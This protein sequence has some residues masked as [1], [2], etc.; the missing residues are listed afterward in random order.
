MENKKNSVSHITHRKALIDDF[1]LIFEL[2]DQSHF[3]YP[4]KIERIRPYM[5]VVER[6]WRNGLS[7]SGTLFW[8]HIAEKPEQK[9]TATLT[10]WKTTEKSWM[11]QHLTS[12]KCP[13]VVG[14]MLRNVLE[15][16]SAEGCHSGQLWFRPE[17][18]Q[19]NK[20]FTPVFEQIRE[21]TRYVKTLCFFD[22]TPDLI[23]SPVSSI[24]IRSCEER[25]I[26]DL[27]AFAVK[28][29][30]R[31]FADAEDLS[32]RDVCL[33]ELDSQY[34]R[35]S[36]MRRRYC[37]LAA[38]SGRPDYP[39]GAAIAYRGSLGFNLSLL[40]NRCE[41][42]VDPTLDEKMSKAVIF[43]LI[44]AAKAAYPLNNNSASPCF[45]PFKY[46]PV[47][48]E[49]H[50][51]NF[52]HSYFAA[53]FKTYNHCIWLYDGFNEWLQAIG[54][55]YRK[56]MERAG[57]L[58]NIADVGRSKGYIM[59]DPRE[60]ERLIQK[61]DP[62]QVVESCILEHLRSGEIMLDLGCGPGVIL[63]EVKRR[64]PDAAV[65][66]ADISRSRTLEAHRHLKAY[67]KAMA[68]AADVSE[69][70]FQSDSFDLVFARFLFQF[71]KHPERILEEMIRVCSPG[72]TIVIQ[73]LDGQLLWHYPPD[74][75]LEKNIGD[76]IAF[77]SEHH[78][79]D[80]FV[81]RKL[82]HYMHNAGLDNINVRPEI[83][84][85]YPG[86]IPER[87]RRH[88]ELKLSI[89]LPKISGFLGGRKS[90]EKLKERFMNYLLREDTLTYSVVFTV[91]GKKLGKKKTG[92]L[93]ER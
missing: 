5:D 89:I 60:A 57:R 19:V 81:G 77:L 20:L 91:S 39:I 83:Y 25:D 67:S 74:A 28:I 23:P 15:K 6:N 76:A 58:K 9:K 34:R 50:L 52:F 13:D 35:F 40:E 41:L 86:K 69:L 93:D 1:P 80:P 18:K 8:T 61:V 65:V 36:L 17:N 46:I 88:W 72:K 82:Y 30:G 73:D 32:N 53:P 21:N 22:V 33:S 55:R 31:V 29:R 70:P 3:F 38:D 12:N 68:V 24:A 44:Q 62:P 78:G 10:A 43:S 14:K 79:F 63:Q 87:N 45:Y 56:V 42:I 2:Y 92:A 85:L 7:T 4:K 37:W 59:D 11:A 49:T 48:V 71:M 26:P 51:A 90:A 64:I 16:S 27:Y 54:T 47:L 75:D 84:H 66:G